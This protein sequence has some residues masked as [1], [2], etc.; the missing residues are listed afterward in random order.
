[1]IQPVQITPSLLAAFA[2][3]LGG[4]LLVGIERERSKG[5]GPGRAV[6][7]IR[8]FALAAAAGAAAQAV[9]QPW[10]VAAGAALIAALTGITYWRQRTDDPGV[11]TEL[12]LFLTYV[13]G[14]AAVGDAQLAAAGFVVVAVLLASKTRLHRFATEVLSGSEIRDGL[15][16]AAA[17]LVFW[18]LIPDRPVALLAGTNPH[19]LWRLVVLLMALQAI[20]YIAVRS[21]SARIGIVLAGLASGLVSSTSTVAAMGA[22]AR[23]QPQLAAACAAG[24]L[25]SNTSS[26]LLVFPVATAIHAPVLAVIW[27][28]LLA[29]MAACLAAVAFNA[30]GPA[31]EGGASA[32]PGPVFNIGQTVGFALFLTALT[33][34]VALV[35]Q[36]YGTTAAGAV[37]ALTATVDMQ[38][39]IGALFSLAAHGELGDGAIMQPLL[40]VLSANMG[41]KVLI[42]WVTGGRAF[43][44][45]MAA[46]LLGTLAAMWATLLL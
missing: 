9:G 31:D 18:P 17:A 2:A 16:L 40:A 4:G 1:M 36:R 21:V 27:P 29:G 26:M 32:S 11:T 42:A 19:H 41:C 30:R 35:T 3:A 13:L 22:R 25:S 43:G 7:G 6:A 8:S 20:G 46:G 37:A 10:L 24:A 33:G 45:R 15:I 14:V 39:S 44:L 12:A 5:S 23:R 38:A 34:I 28:A